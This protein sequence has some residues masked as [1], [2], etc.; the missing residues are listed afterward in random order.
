MTFVVSVPEA[1]LKMLSLFRI[2]SREESWSDTRAGG[3][4][5]EIICSHSA[6]QRRGQ[7]QAPRDESI[8]TGSR[9]HRGTQV[10]ALCYTLCESTR[11]IGVDAHAY[12]TVA[13]DAALAVPGT[14]TLPDTLLTNA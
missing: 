5:I 7:N 8:T 2:T 9:S 4:D 11:L 3:L 13:I 10:A 6:E 14:V 1:L 12:L